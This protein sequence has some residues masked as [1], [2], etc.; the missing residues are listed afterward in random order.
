MNLEQLNERAKAYKVDSIYATEDGNF[1]Y[2]EAKTYAEAH[3][4]Q[5]KS[6]LHLI[7]NVVQVEGVVE[8]DKL[9]RTRKTK[10]LKAET[11]NNKE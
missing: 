3:S 6:K 9:K 11:T 7:S 8:E 2:V 10:E 5:S 1:F 4:K